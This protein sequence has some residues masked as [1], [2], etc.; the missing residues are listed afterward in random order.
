MY[1]AEGDYGVLLVLLLIAVQ[2]VAVELYAA[3]VCVCD[4]HIAAILVWLLVL[5]PV[6]LPVL[7]LVLRCAAIWGVLRAECVAWVCV[8]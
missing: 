4:G 8:W 7:S 5:L 6:L 2:L 1:G 3:L